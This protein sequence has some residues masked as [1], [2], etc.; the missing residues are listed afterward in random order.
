M[1]KVLQSV[2]DKKRAMTK[3]KQHLGKK[4]M[5]DLLMEAEDEDGQK[6]EDEYIVD[7]LLLFLSAGF[8]S[9]ALATLWAIVHLTEHPEALKRAKKLKMRNLNLMEQLEIIVSYQ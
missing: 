1:V 7:L 6:L 9:S 8:D 5:M 4:D 2:L 3:S